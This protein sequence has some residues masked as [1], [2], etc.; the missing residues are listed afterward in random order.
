VG[1]P[2][3]HEGFDPGVCDVLVGNLQGGAVAEVEHPCIHVRVLR[4]RGRDVRFS[5]LRSAVLEPFGS[6]RGAG[7]ILPSGP[8]GAMASFGSP[9]GHGLS[10]GPCLERGWTRTNM[11][12]RLRTGV[13]LAP[14]RV[15][16]R[17]SP[18]RPAPTCR[19]LLGSAPSCSSGDTAPRPSTSYSQL[20]LFSQQYVL[21]RFL[22]WSL[23]Y[24]SITGVLIWKKQYMF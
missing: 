8:L 3:R 22:Y 1:L 19:A 11:D 24:R 6:T 12:A 17:S 16:H 23:L 5:T 15:E 10:V 7:T 2:I 14:R 13:A 20:E 18:P 9:E 4:R 21:K